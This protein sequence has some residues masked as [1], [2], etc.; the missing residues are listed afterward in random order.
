MEQLAQCPRIEVTDESLIHLVSI[1][2]WALFLS[3]MGFV[4]C[5]FMLLAGLSIGV[6]SSFIPSAEGI[7]ALPGVLLFILYAVMAVVYF[8]PSLFLYNFSMRL[9][10][11]LETR[12]TGLF[13]E[14]LKYLKYQFTFIGLMVIVGICLMILGLI[15][16][17]AIGLFT[18]LKM[19]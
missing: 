10:T 7:G 1:R 16:A 18:G 12:A 9:K 11:A 19:M 8:I 17:V 13:T 5:G 6:L 15:A 4:G 14:A 3:I 2:K